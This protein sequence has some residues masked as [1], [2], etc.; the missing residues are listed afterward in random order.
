MDFRSSV[1]VPGTDPGAQARGRRAVARADRIWELPGGQAPWHRVPVRRRST[2]G[3]RLAGHCQSLGCWRTERCFAPL[4]QEELRSMREKGV[5]QFRGN[6]RN[7]WPGSFQFSA[8]RKKCIARRLCATVPNSEFRTGLKSRSR[9]VGSLGAMQRRIG[10]LAAKGV[11]VTAAVIEGNAK[12]CRRF[13]G[14]PVAGLRHC[15]PLNRCSAVDCSPKPC[16]GQKRCLQHCGG[17]PEQSEVI[18]ACRR[19][20]L[21]EERPRLNPTTSAWWTGRRGANLRSRQGGPCRAGWRRACC[22]STG[23]AWMALVSW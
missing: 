2:S 11:H 15:S 22:E 13:S 18:I 17:R 19:S 8:L 23:W 1:H 4:P 10:E 7:G 9:T 20:R 14:R 3:K 6:T 21:L 5:V 12:L 16:R